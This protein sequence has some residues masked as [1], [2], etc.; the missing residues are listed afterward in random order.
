MSLWVK[1]ITNTMSKL[2]KNQEAD[3]INYLILF[4]NTIPYTLVAGKLQQPWCK[5][6]INPGQN[7]CGVFKR[8][9]HLFNSLG[10]DKD[11]KIVDRL[12][13][14]KRNFIEINRIFFTRAMLSHLYD[15]WSMYLF[16]KNM[17]MVISQMWSYMLFHWNLIYTA[18]LLLN[19]VAFKTQ[20]SNQQWIVIP[21]Y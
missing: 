15:I 19:F 16:F 17:C 13:I 1:N 12:C 3:F 20:I 4:G 11:P 9:M 6:Y 18:G 7:T 5:R 8:I 14:Y 2:T 10:S 21:W